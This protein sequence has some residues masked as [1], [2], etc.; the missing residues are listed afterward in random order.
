MRDMRIHG[1]DANLRKENCPK[2]HSYDETNTIYTKE[3]FR[4]CRTCESEKGKEK[5]EREKA[6]MGTEPNHH[7]TI[8]AYRKY[9]CRCLLCAAAIADFYRRQAETKR[10][11]DLSQGPP[12]RHGTTGGYSRGCR[13]DDCRAA[14]TAYFRER[15]R[16]RQKAA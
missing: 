9:G 8:T 1:T 6:F 10:R 13:C 12:V 5:R 4:R 14:N 16:R 3:G 2:R 11:R 7:G 15:R